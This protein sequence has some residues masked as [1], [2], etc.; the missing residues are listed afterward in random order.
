MLK[1]DAVSEYTWD[2][3]AMQIE[4]EKRDALWTGQG[5]QGDMPMLGLLC[6]PGLCLLDEFRE[7]HVPPARGTPR[8]LPAV[9]AAGAA[10]PADRGYRADSAAYQ[11]ALITVL[12]TDRVAWAIRADGMTGV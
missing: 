2:A 12:E 7:G 1:R 10:R 6:E 9:P 11:A 4:G 8:V 5:V 3:D